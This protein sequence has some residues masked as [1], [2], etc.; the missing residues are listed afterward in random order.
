M[1]VL[2]AHTEAAAPWGGARAG[3]AHRGGRAVGCRSTDGGAG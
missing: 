1:P 3:R 2:D